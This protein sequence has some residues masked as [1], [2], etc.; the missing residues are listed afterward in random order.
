MVMAPGQAQQQ[1]ANQ[2]AS[3]VVLSSAILDRYPGEYKHVAA[4]TIATVR[5]DGDKLLVKV[6][7]SIQPEI[8]FAARSETLF[9]SG[10]Y[11]LEFQLDGQGRATGAIWKQ[12][13]DIIPLVR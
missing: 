9:A 13:S 8:T 6:Q 10:P 5:R 1:L 4:G 11:T 7:G 3:A 12:F 2:A